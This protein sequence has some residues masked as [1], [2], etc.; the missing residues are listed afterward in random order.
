M[1]PVVVEVS[2]S[3]ETAGIQDVL[4][5]TF[6]RTRAALHDGA[7]VAL[8]VDDHALAGDASP[9]ASAVAAARASAHDRLVW[10]RWVPVALLLTALLLLGQALRH[11]STRRAPTSVQQ[12]PVTEG[13]THV[14]SLT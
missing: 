13:T 5:D 6:T 14:D 3:C 8:L 7:A 4:W 2:G 11:R 10:T 1:P 9:A 12:A